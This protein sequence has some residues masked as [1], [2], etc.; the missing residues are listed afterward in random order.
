MQQIRHAIENGALKDGDQLP[1]IR[2]L[3]EE[4]VVSPGTII[5]AY[6]G[7]EMEGVIEVQHGAG[8]FVSRNRRARRLSERVQAARERVGSLIADLRNEGLLDDEIRRL[9]E[10]GLLSSS[11]ARHSNSK[12]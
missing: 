12:P 5:K 2:A 11:K 6:T 3:A 1:S 4:L 9:F 8:V 10:A 7:L